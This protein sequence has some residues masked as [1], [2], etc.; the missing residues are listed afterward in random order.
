MLDA[1]R[2]VGTMMDEDD[3][4]GIMACRER[5]TPNPNIAAIGPGKQQNY[6]LIAF[7]ALL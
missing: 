4:E 1:V 7:C 6:V 3:N 5:R 2:V